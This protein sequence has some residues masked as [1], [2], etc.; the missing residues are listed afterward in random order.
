MLFF[1]IVDI[2]EHILTLSFP[3]PLIHIYTQLCSIIVFGCVANQ[4]SNA[5][6][7]ATVTVCGYNGNSDAC[8]FAIAVGVLGFLLCLAFLVKDVL[9][10]IV[11]YSNNIVVS[12]HLNTYK[13]YGDRLYKHTHIDMSLF[14]RSWDSLVHVYR[15]HGL[16]SATRYIGY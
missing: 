2:A 16:L 1:S 9:F 13:I 8:N 12:Q 10:V 3:F 15:I 7:S 11:D 6:L 5:P 14:V 4:V